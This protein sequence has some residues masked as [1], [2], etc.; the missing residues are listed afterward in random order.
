MGVYISC[1]KFAVFCSTENSV[2]YRDIWDSSF[3]SGQ[4]IRIKIVY[5]ASSKNG[6]NADMDIIPQSLFCRKT[7]NFPCS[8]SPS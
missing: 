7:Q 4:A 2:N 8:F 6:N 3:P 1:A 5:L